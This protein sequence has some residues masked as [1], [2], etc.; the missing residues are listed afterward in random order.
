M[1]SEVKQQGRRV[2]LKQDYEDVSG[3]PFKAGQT[4]IALGP[5]DGHV[6]VDFDG[7]EQQRRAR[8]TN[9]VN[10]SADDDPVPWMGAIPAD[11]LVPSAEG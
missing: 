7:Y 2:R 4:G 9:P 6:L 3:L 8:A 11:L 10:G 5:L 1:N